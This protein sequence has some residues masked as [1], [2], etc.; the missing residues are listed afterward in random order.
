MKRLICILFALMMLCCTA[1]AFAEGVTCDHHYKLFPRADGLD[2]YTCIC[3]KGCETVFNVYPVDSAA[4]RPEAAEETC[5]HV[6]R[7][8]EEVKRV[9]V[10]SVSQYSHEAAQWYDCVCE[11]CDEAFEAYVAVGSSYLHRVSE[12]EG[13]HIEGELKHLF[14]GHCDDCGQLRYERVNCYRD[15]NGVCTSG[16]Y[17]APE[18]ELER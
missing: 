17:I 3:T 2:Y 15:E 5:A 1:Q 13:I 4:E 7:M 8:D 10:E 9:S 11:Y 12:W 18:A 14:V 6:F 16:A